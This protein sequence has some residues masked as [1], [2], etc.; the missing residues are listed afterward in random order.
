[1]EIE[2]VSVTHCQG[3]NPAS[4]PS[5]IP[6]DLIMNAVILEVLRF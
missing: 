2:L 6:R 4:L 5:S 3:T 1:M